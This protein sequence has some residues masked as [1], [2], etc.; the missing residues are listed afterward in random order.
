MQFLSVGKGMKGI[1]VNSQYSDL[2]KWA[3]DLIWPVSGNSSLKRTSRLCRTLFW[4]G[5][6]NLILWSCLRIPT[7]CIFLPWNLTS[8]SHLWECGHRIHNW[9]NEPPLVL[10][11][12]MLDTASFLDCTWRTTISKVV[13][14]VLMTNF[15]RFQI[16]MFQTLLMC[17]LLH[18][19]SVVSSVSFHCFSQIQLSI[20]ENSLLERYWLLLSVTLRLCTFTASC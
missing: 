15:L 13:S 5:S 18:C 16:S 3:H 1:I 7:V 6:N 2:W 4:I 19:Q 10:Y 20:L 9:S 14:G 12:A 11:H 8:F 17:I